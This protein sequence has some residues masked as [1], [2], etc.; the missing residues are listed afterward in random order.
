MMPAIGPEPG[1]PANVTILHLAVDYNTPHRPRTTTAVEWFVGELTGFDN[2]VIALLRTARLSVR[3]PVECAAAAGRLFDVSF[4][5]LPFGI[6]LHRAMRRAATAIIALLEQQGIRPSLVHAHKFTFEGLAGWYVARHFDVPLFISLRG[7]V[8]TKVFRAKPLLRPLLRRIA[9]DAARLYFVSAWFEPMFHAFVPGEAAKARRLPNIVRNI[10]PTISITPPDRGLVSVFNLDTH[11]RKGLAWL[12]DAMVIAVR[13]EPD[14]TL[15]IIGGGSTASF[16][17]C[18]AMIAQRGL[19]ASVQ[20]VGALANA[21]LLQRLPHYRGMALPSLNETFGMV[22][23][24]S[25]FAGIPVLY[26][27][28]TAVDGYL[29]G[30][31]V[32]IAVPPRDS[33][34]IAAGL[35]ALWRGSGRFR[36]NI[37]RAGPALF[38]A[39]DPATNI[40]RYE[41]DVRLAVG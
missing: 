8:E 3:P 1:E 30:L 16:Q 12:L 36:E 19:G 38:A 22:Y 18:A 34:A 28:G 13:A 32:A 27:A 21:E 4:F 37:G 29:D 5:G 40:L 31:G 2:V 7:E 24:E 6:G 15:D 23:V 10:S 11:K 39:F 20:L 35:L 9:H 26:T 41:E 25:L 17:R 14:C 33:A